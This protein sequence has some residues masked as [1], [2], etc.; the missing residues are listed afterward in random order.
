MSSNEPESDPY[1]R[2]KYLNNA[3][4]QFINPELFICPIDGNTWWRT[5]N[6]KIIMGNLVVYYYYQHV[7]A[8]YTSTIGLVISENWDRTATLGRVLNQINKD[9]SIRINRIEVV[10]RLTKYLKEEFHF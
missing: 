4:D 1:W 6:Q 9:K 2:P 5:I 8:F 10:E 3:R 7:V